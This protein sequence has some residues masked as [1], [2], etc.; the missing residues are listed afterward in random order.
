[1]AYKKYDLK[2]IEVVA[3]G[4]KQKTEDFYFSV[5]N[6]F[7]FCVGFISLNNGFSNLHYRFYIFSFWDLFV[8]K[9]RYALF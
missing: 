8:F 4:T 3:S 9:K 7:L 5:K 6:W 2:T 1:L